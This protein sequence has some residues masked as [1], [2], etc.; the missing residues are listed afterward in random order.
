[1]AAKWWGPK[2]IRPILVIHDTLDNAGSFDALIPLLPSHLSYLAIDSPGRGKSCRL[3]N[4]M[5]YSSIDDL[6]II[7][8]IIHQF[9][10]E[11]VSLMAHEQGAIH[12]YMYAATFPQRVDMV[13]ALN[14]LSPKVINP[15]VLTPL[16]LRLEHVLDEDLLNQSQ[17]I[18]TYTYDE[19]IEQRTSAAC[20]A[21]TREVAPMLLDREVTESKL[22][23]NQ[24]I[25]NRDNR[26]RVYYAAMYT[27]EICLRMA[28]SITSPFMFLRTIQTPYTDYPRYMLEVLNI[29]FGKST[30]E[31]ISI[32]ARCYVHLSNP[33]EISN[34]ISTFICEHRP[35]P[36]KI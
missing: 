5:L 18:K 21:L 33:E 23:P 9:K 17:I 2:N 3:P 7:N 28:E 12:C 36:S 27:H 13:I 25:L 22:N 8:Y 29:L 31:C 19:L 24:F 32:N 26:L 16:L 4:G 15:K 20:L 34:L 1:M 11:K 35:V 10:W 6:Y 30:F 14:G